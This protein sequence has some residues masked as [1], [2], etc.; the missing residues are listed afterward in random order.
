MSACLLFDCDGTLV[1]SERLCNIGLVRMFERLGVIL[2]ADDL[3]ARFRGWKLAEILD[4]LR[5][6]NSVVLPDDF[7]PR[8]REIVSQLFETELKPTEG[9]EQALANLPQSKAVVSSGPSHK[10]RQALRVCGLSDY[11]GENIFSSYDIGIWKPDPGIYLRA[12]ERMGFNPEQ[13]SVIDDSH[14]GV[15]AGYKAGMTTYFYNLFDQPC[16]FPGVV[17]FKS[18][19]SLPDYLGAASAAGVS[20]N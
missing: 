2:D 12:A 11:F 17:S 16:H 15:E 13:C 10:I 8:Y 7:V 5:L 14:L 3:V 20:R 18:M 19:L 4:V 9:V 1:D 6:E